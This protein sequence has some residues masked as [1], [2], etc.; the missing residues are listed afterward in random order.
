MKIEVEI[1]NLAKDPVKN[2]FLE[3]VIERTLLREEFNYLGKKTISLSVALISKQEIRKLNK[4]YRKKDLVTD[5]LSFAEFTSQ[6]RIKEFNEKYILL[7]EVIVCYDDIVRY[8]K[9]KKIA[10]NYELAKVISHGVLHLLG[11]RHGKKMFEIQEGVAN[12]IKLI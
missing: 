2:S 11:F 12:N 7:G 6:K 4:R 3:K 9:K 10:E 5:V 8:A 1:N